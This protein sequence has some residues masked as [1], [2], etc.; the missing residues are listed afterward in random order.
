ML[1]IRGDTSAGAAHPASFAL[2][3]TIQLLSQC[4]RRLRRMLAER[5][6]GWGLGDTEFL[7]LWLCQRAGAQGLAQRDLADSLGVSAPQMSGL[8]ERLR[9]RKL[10]TSRRC[11]LDRRRQLWIID[12]EGQQLLVQISHDLEQLTASLD[13]SLSPQQR[14][15]LTSLL[16]S[17]ADMEL[18]QPALKVFRP[19]DE[20][21]NHVREAD[22]ARA[23]R[24]TG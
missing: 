3:E 5:L 6:G 17:L 18:E 11:R 24:T 22:D 12:A 14:Q 7:V 8:V 9:Q 23:P 21:F 13:R 15:L 2:G 10:L 1:P 4:H 16:R 19:S 20:E